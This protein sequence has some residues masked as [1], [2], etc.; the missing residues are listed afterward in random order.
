MET[1]AKNRDSTHHPPKKRPHNARLRQ[2]LP[3]DSLIP[4]RYS[5]LPDH[6]NRN[7]EIGSIRVAL[8]AGTQTAASATAHRKIGV[9]TKAVGSHVFTPNRNPVRNFVS[10]KA[11]PIPMTSPIP[12]SNIPWRITILRM[13]EAGSPQCHPDAQFQ[14]SLLHRVSH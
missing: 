8:L 3:G 6:S 10:Q 2:R 1:M 11:P 13:L 7:A 12:A 9:R 5:S 4:V 14:G